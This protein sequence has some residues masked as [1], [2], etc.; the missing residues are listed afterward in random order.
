MDNRDEEQNT[1]GTGSTTETGNATKSETKLGNEVPEP[2][3]DMVNEEKRRFRCARNMVTFTLSYGCSS[4]VTSA[5]S[6]YMSS[7][8]TTLERQFGLSSGESGIILSCNDFGFLLTVLL[9]GHFGP[10]FHIP[11]LLS[12]AVLLYGV[13]GLMCSLPQFVSGFSLTPKSN[14]N[15]NS[16]EDSSVIALCRV[17]GNVP[18]EPC[19]SEETKNAESIKWVVVYLGICLGIQGVGK[20][21]RSP[22]GTLYIDNNTE[23]G[24]TGLYLGVTTAMGLMGPFIALMLGGSFGKLPVDLK[25]TTMTP[26]DSRWIGAWWLG[27]LLFGTLSLLAA[28]PLATFPRRLSSAPSGND[29]RQDSNGNTNKESFCDMIKS[30]PRGIYNVLRCAVFDIC[31]AAILCLMFGAMGNTIFGPKYLENQFNIPTWKA[32]MI[33][34]VEKLGT[35]IIGVCLGGYLTS[36]MRMNRRKCLKMVVILSFIT[37]SLSSLEFIFGCEN[38]PIGGVNKNLVPSAVESCHCDNVPYQAV[39]GSDGQSFTTPCHAGC[40]NVTENL[41]SD[42]KFVSGDRKARPGICD[43]GCAFLIPYVAVSMVS[44]L[45]ATMSIMPIYLVFLRSVPEESRALALGILSAA[46]ALLVFIPTPIAFGKIYDSVCL[47]WKSTCGVRGAC[48]LYD[49]VNMRYR[50][51]AIDVGCRAC[52]F[53][54]HMV[55]LFI[56]TR[57]DKDDDSDEI[58]KD[59]DMNLKSI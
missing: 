33:L 28:I 59:T 46:V 18:T 3:S 26:E 2:E 8:I 55:A 50:L 53:L 58:N 32:N 57:Q 39:C 48:G 15:A 45:A 41:Y 25:D 17:E 23:K 38:P 14:N 44:T 5:L 29:S 31:L 22:L 34:G 9:F 54:L 19:S 7:Q 12:M 30:I 40:Q 4:L 1:T 21:P 56:A 13:S 49:I 24:K 52:A 47:I 20:S 6:L 35:G 27:F 10:R 51:V 36:R 42:C 11:H 43:T 37:T 16:S